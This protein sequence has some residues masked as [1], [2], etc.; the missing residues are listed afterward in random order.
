MKGLKNN[1]FVRGVYYLIR[2]YFEHR[3]SNFV[4]I[5]DNQRITPPV[6]SIE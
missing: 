6:L 3:E 1:R 5:I 2:N 4:Q